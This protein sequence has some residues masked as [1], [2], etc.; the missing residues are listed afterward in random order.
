MPSKT[1]SNAKSNNKSNAKNKKKFKKN[2]NGNMLKIPFP[3]RFLCHM[4]YSDTYSLSQ[5]VAG[6][7]AYQQF[8]LNSIYDPDKTGV[9]H[10]SYYF[11]QILQTD[12][13]NS[14][15][16]HALKYV[17][18]AT[19][20][21]DVVIGVR[22]SNLATAPTDLDLLQERPNSKTRT[23]ADGGKP[24]TLTGFISCAQVAGVNKRRIAD[25]D[26]YTGAY[27]ANPVTLLYLN[28]IGRSIADLG[29]ANIYLSVKLTYYC[30]LSNLKPNSGS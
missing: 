5:S 25:D 13:Y 19:A 2:I 8:H 17:I 14:F 10:K 29:T 16:V 11:D 1:K 9:G 24:V 18:T 26:I 22:P 15:T 3:P 21:A 27:N 20:D 23:Y 6:T 30:S 7:A 28:V 12:M 4:N